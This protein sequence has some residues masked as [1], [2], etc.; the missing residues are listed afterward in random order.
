MDPGVP[1]GLATGGVNPWK[2]DSQFGRGSCKTSEWPQESAS[3]AKEIT[4][5]CLFFAIFA[6]FC[7]SFAI[8]VSGEM[9][10]V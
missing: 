9:K 4:F 3:N 7:G 10:L 6:P 2:S 5:C 8:P 1:A